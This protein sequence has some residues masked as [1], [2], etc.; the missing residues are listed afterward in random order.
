MNQ[1]GWGLPLS[2]VIEVKQFPLNKKY[3][4][5]G[6]RES[7]RRP[8]HWVTWEKKGRERRRDK[9]SVLI[10]FKVNRHTAN[11]KDNTTHYTLRAEL[12]CNQCE[13]WSSLPG[14]TTHICTQTHTTHVCMYVH[15]WTH[16]HIYTPVWRVRLTSG[17]RALGWGLRACATSS[18]VLP[19]LLREWLF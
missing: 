8:L 16:T 5:T 13:K 7:Q 9:S 17:S 11:L 1:L 19:Q 4:L 10:Q 6:E 14:H 15:T 18:C 3:V 12:T 2:A